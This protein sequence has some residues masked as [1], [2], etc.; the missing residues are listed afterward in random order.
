MPRRKK[1]STYS[2]VQRQIA[3]LQAQ[4]EA[5]KKREVAEVVGKIRAAI[6][7]YGLTAADLGLSGKPDKRAAVAAK[8]RGRALVARKRKSVVPIR[9]RDANGNTWTGRG[10]RAR[11]L[12]AAL[13]Q[14]KK[15][16]DFL[17]K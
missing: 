8:G 3:Q 13:A 10:S 17:V 12:V 9:Y 16:E 4:A 2:E 15:L 1:A 7:H 14:G 5:L 11:W 6:A